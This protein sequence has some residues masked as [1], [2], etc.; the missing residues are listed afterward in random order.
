MRRHFVVTGP[1]HRRP[2]S[3]AISRHCTASSPCATQALVPAGGCLR[4]RKARRHRPCSWCAVSAPFARRRR[5]RRASH[6]LRTL[7]VRGPR[8][9]RARRRS[10]LPRSRYVSERRPLL[11]A[12]CGGAVG[13][14]SQRRK[15]GGGGHTGEVRAAPRVDSHP[16]ACTHAHKRW[17]RRSVSPTLG[18]R[19]RRR[20]AQPGRWVDC[21]DAERLTRRRYVDDTTYT[22]GVG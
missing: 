20:V 21:G 9:W 15:L 7:A 16:H 10:H 2:A 22:G 3:D 18:P 1:P 8:T 14:M 17:S 4:A 11:P 12:A 13:S 5:R 19:R 6:L